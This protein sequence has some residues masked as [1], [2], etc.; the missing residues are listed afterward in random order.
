MRKGS[1]LLGVKETSFPLHDTDVSE[2]S[3]IADD[4]TDEPPIIIELVSPQV[5][6][7]SEQPLS[8][9]SNSQLSYYQS[10][11]QCSISSTAIPPPTDVPTLFGSLACSTPAMNPLQ[12]SPGH[13]ISQSG[14][15]NSK[16]ASSF[17]TSTSLTVTATPVSG[18]GL[19]SSQTSSKNPAAHWPPEFYADFTSHVWITYR[20]HFHPI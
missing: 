19:S 5:R 17:R 8:S 16:Q 13:P 18:N 2:N 9:V 4:S 12:W 11:R 3:S 14:L 1:K 15:V 10:S 6:M 20:S 7:R